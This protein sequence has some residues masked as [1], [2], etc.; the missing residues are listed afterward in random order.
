MRW[1]RRT[2][3][4]SWGM[5]CSTIQ[6]LAEWLS[7]VNSRN[8]SQILFYDSVSKDSLILFY[9]SVFK[10]SIPW[11]NLDTKFLIFRVRPYLTEKLASR[12]VL[13][14]GIALCG[15]VE[16]GDGDR[17]KPATFNFS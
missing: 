4:F 14:C 8:S 16:G 1:Q 10:D 11:L 5:K 3:V 9:D 15:D 13:T 2:G 6:I 17:C 7:N 12:F